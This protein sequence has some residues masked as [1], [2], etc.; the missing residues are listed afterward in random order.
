[1]EVVSLSQTGAVKAACERKG[2][3]SHMAS[4]AKTRSGGIVALL[5]G[6]TIWGASFPVVQAGLSY[7]GPFEFLTLRFLIASSVLVPYSLSS[8]SRRAAWTQ[9]GAWVLGICLF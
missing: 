4:R 7:F 8:P 2:S 9:P 3:I 6:V 1:M 5:V